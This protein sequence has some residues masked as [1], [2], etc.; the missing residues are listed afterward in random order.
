VLA[1]CS[2]EVFE[3]VR[4]GVDGR[5]VGVV[6]CGVELDLF[7]P[8]GPREERPPGLHRIVVVGR[9]VE[10]KGVGEVIAALAELP[11]TELHVAGGPP[12]AGLR[13]D[14]EARRLLGLARRH[15]VADRVHL[16]GRVARA[17]LPPLLRSADVLVSAPWYE[18]FGIAPLEAMACAVPVV[19]TA[20]GGQIDSVVHGVTGVHVP[21][22]DPAALARAISELLSDPARRE[23]LGAGGARR[24]RERYGWDRVAEATHDAYATLLGAG[25]RRAEGVPA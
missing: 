22:R 17:D 12:R 18:P 2:D 5:Q 13:S 9:L 23:A 15:G 19:A 14:P 7:R 16:R 4:L 1:T 11:G 8:D 10:R 25:A 21:P 6:P 20:V 24:A 3:L